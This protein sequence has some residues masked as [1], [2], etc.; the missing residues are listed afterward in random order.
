MIKQ[1]YSPEDDLQH[2]RWLAAA[3]AD[4]RYLRVHGRPLFLVYRPMHLP[5]PRRTTDTIRNEVV[6][7]GLPNPFLFGVN[8]HS[9]FQDSRELGFDGTVH[10]EP[11]LGV[12]P[13]Y[14]HDGPSLAKLL[15]NLRFGVFSP[16]LKLYDYAEARRLMKKVRPAFPH[17]PTIFVGWGNTPRRGRNAIVVLN[18]TPERFEAGL[19]ELVQEALHKPYE[20]RLN[21]R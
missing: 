3:F 10:F 12:L 19:R 20:E 16:Y 8:A 1:T 17:Y 14:M 21:L 18:S 5:D 4:P 2:A 6:R 7:L 11:A 13:D 15:R 9:T